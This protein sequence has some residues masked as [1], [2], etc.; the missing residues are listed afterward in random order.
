MK[1]CPYCE[2]MDEEL[3]KVSKEL[4]INTMKI[5]A[6][7]EPELIKSYGIRGFPSLLLLEYTPNGIKEY[8]LSG[9]ADSSVIIEWI[10]KVKGSAIAVPEK[11]K[12]EMLICKDACP[13]DEKCYPFGYR[14]GGK[15]CSDDGMFKEELKDDA[16][17]E[18][19][20]ECKTNVCVDG[21]CMSSGL[22][23]KILNWF[24]KLF[25]SQ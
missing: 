16:T 14:K 8:I 22:I 25:G 18:N 2:G 10:G 24:R 15:F 1:D 20:F 12:E 4:G 3:D 21:K 11:P 19:N 9:K 17:C 13:L 23:Q 6:N 5:D 7:A